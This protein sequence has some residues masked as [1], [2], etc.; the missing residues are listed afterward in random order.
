MK[1]LLFSHFLKDTLKFFTLMCLSLSLIVWVIQ[2]VNYLDFV[3][4]D[5][6]SLYVY[7]LFTVHN[8]PKIIHRILPFVFFISL[9]YQINRYELKNELIIFWSIGISKSYFVKIILIFSLFFLIIQTILGGYISPMSQDKARDYIRNSNIDFFPSLLQEGK[10]IDTVQN[11]TI[12]ILSEEPYGTY[13]NIFLKE[14]FNPTKSKVVYAKN[15]SLKVDGKKKYLELFDGQIIN[16]DENK[17]NHFSF[18]KIDFDLT[19]YTSKSISFPKIQELNSYLLI[20]CLKYN[21]KGIKLE[22]K[23]LSCNN[24]ITKNIKEEI[25]K[26]FYKPI[27][28]PLLSLLACLIF[29]TSKENG[30]FSFNRS[31]IFFI[32]ILTI[33]ISE[34]SLRYSIESIVGMYFF[35]IF[36]L[37]AILCLYIYLLTKSKK[38]VND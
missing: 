12:F 31:A 29:F 35:F 28:I 38:T 6:H 7:F 15:G 34:V 8:F 18:S 4:E 30:K 2:A 9:F 32:G 13:N 14:N 3:T 16:K 19:Q 27:Y 5:G 37:L 20:K 23:V 36:P 1:K 10:F 24:K 33:V 11:L 22:S 17:V 25:F 26:R 21:A